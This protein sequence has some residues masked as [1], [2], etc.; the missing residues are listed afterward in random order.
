MLVVEAADFFF[1]AGGQ[2]VYLLHGVAGGWDGDS[3]DEGYGAGME[4]AAMDGQKLVGSNEGDGHDGNLS[5]DGHEGWS[6]EEGLGMAGLRAAAFGEDEDREPCFESLY[7]AG[8]ALDGGQ[9]V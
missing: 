9:R 6:V 1:D 4:E 8:E 5:A 7:G 2:L 3:G